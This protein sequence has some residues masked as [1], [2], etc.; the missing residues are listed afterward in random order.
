MKKPEK[1]EVREASGSLWFGLILTVVTAIVAWVVLKAVFAAF[2][3]ILVLAAVGIALYA[4]AW[5]LAALRR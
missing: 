1:S 5:L 4:A 3:L 2:S